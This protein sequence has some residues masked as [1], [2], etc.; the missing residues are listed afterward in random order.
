MVRS[1]KA[2]NSKLTYNKKIYNKMTTCEICNTKIKNFKIHVRSNKHMKNTNQSLLNLNYFDDKKKL[3]SMCNK[4]VLNLKIHEK[5]KIHQRNSMQCDYKN[6]REGIQGNFKAYCYTNINIIDPRTFIN[7]MMSTIENKI[8]DQNWKNLKLSLSLHVEFYKN[9]PDG[10]KQMINNWFNSGSMTSITNNSQI[11]DTIHVMINKIEEKICKFTRKG[12]GWIIKKLLDFEIKVAKYKPL[13][14][15]SYIETPSKYKNPKFGLINIQNK[16]DNECFKWCIA[17]SECL[18]EDNVHRLSTKVREA[19]K[20]YNW[21]GI[22]FPVQLKQISKFENQNDVSVNVFGLDDKEI[23]YPLRITKIEKTKHV[24]LLLISDNENTH[25]LLMKHLSPFINKKHENKTYPCRFC[26]HSFY[27]K[28]LLDKHLPECSIHTPVRMELSEGQ[29]QFRL[30]YKQF[31]HPFVIYADFESTLQKIHTTQPNPK[32]SYT[33]NLQKHRPNSWCCYTKC[34]VDE[35]SK[36]KIYE[37]ENASK[38]FVEYLISESKRIY[39]LLQINEPMNLTSEEKIS[40]QNSDRCYVCKRE[41][42]EN[43]FKVRDHNH[44]T[45]EYRGPAHRSCNLQIRE[46]KFVPI[47]MHNLSKYDAHLFVKDFGLVDGQLK[48]IPQTDETYISFS[49]Y[50]KVGEITVSKSINMELRFIDSFRFMSSSLA[51]LASNLS[52]ENFK[53]LSKYYQDDQFKLLRK[54]GVYPYDWM[55]DILKFNYEK[56]PNKEKFYSMLNNED[57]SNE[58]YKHAQNI[59]KKF[60]C[61]TFR[62]YHML[63]LKSDTLLLADVFE[64]FRTTCLD[65]YKLDP[66]RYF[67]SPGLSWDALLKETKVKLDLLKDP[68]MLL[69]IEKGIRGGISTITHRY[70]K[71]NNPYIQESYDKNKP[72]SYI[73]YLDA[74]NL[75]GWAMSQYL[76]TGKFKW[77]KNVNDIDVLDIDDEARKGYILEVDLEYPKELHDLHND[78][79]LAA[80]NLELD[81]VSKLVPNLNNKEKYVIHYRNLKQCLSLGLKLKKVHRIL[82]F[83]QSDWMKSYIELNTNKRKEAK[84][85]FEKDFYKLMNNSVFGKTMENIRNRVDVQLV[86]N[87]E[88]AQKLVNKPNFESFKIFSEN[89]IACHMKKTKLRFDKP[90]YVGMSIL[91]LSKTLMYDFHYNHIKNKYNEKAKLLFTDTDSLCYYIQTK[92]IYKDMKKDKQLFDTSDYPK[93]HKLYSEKNKKV[94]GKM[95]DETAGKLITEFVG[96]RAKLYAFKTLENKEIK[97][98]K[99]VKKSV[100]NQAINIEDYKRALFENET[101][102]R[103]MN[104]IQSKKHDVF[105]TQINKISLSSN[106]DK[107]YI[108]ENNINTLALGH[109]RIS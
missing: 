53:N 19:S 28:E 80:E 7:N 56:L 107:R 9:L 70:A 34:D 108:L 106:D 93:D 104:T 4:S 66:A 3:C 24:D 103:K 49:Q 102:Y 38:T 39:E 78:Y 10:R 69:M 86:K 18:D 61:K 76:P 31:K 109:Y 41:Y 11:K 27:K 94:L 47:I 15:S 72:H 88:Q 51:K 84:N 26:L 81:K 77:V 96:L 37:G 60:K 22:E 55:D 16:N 54:K 50:I 59:W 87:K 13:R 82:E 35:Y 44:L 40:H 71:A 97:K 67:T 32:E 1:E 73:T 20:K 99:G 23:L 63:Y 79:P 62:D 12:S 65:T 95:K 89:L 5:S 36:F 57:I 75:Y 90:I 105:T 6:C 25:Y 2:E 58:D 92:D 14:A 29:V 83:D 46:P 30:H 33:I 91:E 74:N 45:G 52:D 48:A 64:N 98:A 8:Q 21:K 42:T 17:R 101:V 100:I 68:D 85:E 43:D